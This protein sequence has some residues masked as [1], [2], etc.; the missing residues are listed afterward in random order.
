MAT[1]TIESFDQC[2]EQAVIDLIVSIQRDEF[3]FD[4]TAEDQPDLRSIPSF[5]QNGLGGFWVAK[6]NGTVVGT[7]G[8]KDIG[9]GEGALRKMFVASSF[10]SGE[11]KVGPRLLDRL[12]DQAGKQGCTRLF[13]GTTEEFRAAHRFYEKHVF[14][15]IPAE[16]LPPAFPRMALDTRFY[17]RPLG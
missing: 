1:I 3:G 2:G 5:Y 12:I 13:L 14:V 16:S 15:Q 9:N 7:I 10:R 6:S 11:F 4:I 17:M 8:L